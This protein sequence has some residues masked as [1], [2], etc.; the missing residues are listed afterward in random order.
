MAAAPLAGALAVVN[1]IITA[2]VVASVTAIAIYVVVAAA[3]D[4]AGK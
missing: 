2:V 3:A 4:T 1:V